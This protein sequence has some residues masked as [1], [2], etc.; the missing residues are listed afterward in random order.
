MNEAE[1]AQ[2]GYLETQADRALRQEL[3]HHMVD[4][5]VF[6]QM[7]DQCG[8]PDAEGREDWI[9]SSALGR[10]AMEH[11]ERH[12]AG[13]PAT[14]ADLQAGF[15]DALRELVVNQSRYWEAKILEHGGP[16]EARDGVERL[17]HVSATMPLQQIVAE[18][19][20]EGRLATI[21]TT[22]GSLDLDE[23]LPLGKLCDE[24]D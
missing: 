14:Q 13:Q 22:T 7:V 3:Q 24:R 15:E 18:V 10:R 2:S 23:G 11:G 20:N 5:Q 17:Q 12:A 16:R 8:L 4:L 6:R 21:D 1:C 19:L 9:V